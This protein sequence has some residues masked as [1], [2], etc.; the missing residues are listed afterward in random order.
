MIKSQ[1]DIVV[2]G[3]G[4][5]GSSAARVAAENGASVAL[6]HRNN[7]I[8]VPV[9]CAEGISRFIIEKYI[10]KENIKESWIATKADK[11][12]LISPSGKKVDVHLKAS[13]YVL[14]RRVFD[15]DLAQWAAN[16]GAQVF[17][18]AYVYNVEKFD[19]YSLIHVEQYG[20]QYK[21]KAKLVI[22][23]DGVESKIARYFGI[24]TQL[25][26]GDID[27]CAQVLATNIDMKSDRFD[28]WVSED[29]A[30]GGYIWLFPKGENIAN[31]GIGISGKYNGQKTAKQYLDEFLSK[32]FPEASI[33]TNVLGGV[34]ISETLESFVADGLMIVGDAARVA[35]PVTGEGIGP[36][37]STGTRAGKFAAKAINENDTSAKFLKAYEKE[38]R[39]DS[40]RFHSFFYRMKDVVYNTSNSDLE[41]LADSF[42]GRDADTLTLTEVFKKVA[43]NKPKLFL[44]VAKAFAGF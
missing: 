13:G 14:N 25:K 21:V 43:R 42:A 12:R 8:G 38:W 15:M 17:T 30:P 11:C 36:A 22:A 33:L 5:A 26:L 4:P 10:G 2:V 37:L 39:K 29:I 18:S 1:Y 28:F 3:G 40:G 31:I 20:K 44:D 16:E 19:D 24:D 32:N 7:E 9:R 34:P 41:K 35:N 23:A 6:F 27:S